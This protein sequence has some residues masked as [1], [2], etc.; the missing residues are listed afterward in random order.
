MTFVPPI[1]RLVHPGPAAAVIALSA[2]LGAVLS[3]QAGRAPLSVPLLLTVLGVAGSQI[4]TGALN[5]WADRGRDAIAQPDKPIPS[6]GVTP[7]AAL[8]LAVAG[9]VLQLAATIPLG[10]LP[11]ALGLVASASA[12]AYD[13]WLSR[14]PMSVVPYLV[15]FGT[16]P[17]WVAAGVGAPFER[18]A[19]A[20]VIVGPFAAAAHLANALR[21]FDADRRL[22]SRNLAQVLGRATAFRVAGGLALGVAA[23][24]GIAFA[25]GGRLT[26][27]PL[28]L[29]AIGVAA[30]ALGIRS[31]DRLWAGMLM[32]AVAWTA[33]WALGSG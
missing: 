21:D 2:V 27:L 14:R 9:A 12:I 30:V 18:V 7:R 25:V 6:G 22:G 19:L 13:L 1:V 11:V 32:A 4:V 29:G 23:V 31:P 5:D 24:V 3:A 26:P 15:S 17:L 16:L 20:P 28:I 33:A 8:R 10:A